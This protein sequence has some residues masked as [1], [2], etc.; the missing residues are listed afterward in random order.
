MT[1]AWRG[2][3]AVAPQVARRAVRET[4]YDLVAIVASAG[5]VKAMET[6]LEALP[7]DFPIPIALVQHRSGHEPNLLARVLSRHSALTIKL[8]EDGEELQRGTVYLALPQLHLIVAD[9]RTLRLVDGHKIRHVPSS[10]NPLFESAAAKLHGRVIGVV[11]T[12]YDRDG[13]DGVQA[14]RAAGGVVLAQDERTS[15]AFAMPRSAIETGAVDAVLPV[16]AIGP[17]LV[18]LANGTYPFAGAA[19]AHQ[20]LKR[21]RGSNFELSRSS[22]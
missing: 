1:Q 7:E 2:G 19:R 4:P 5:G 10:G 8:A 3:V 11:L 9:N 6:I 15:K 16:E 20:E 21:V 22:S 13:T 14:I 12:G 17:A 18:M